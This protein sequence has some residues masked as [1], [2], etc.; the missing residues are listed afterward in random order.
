MIAHGSVV[1]SALIG[2][3][4]G[5]L[6]S[7]TLFAVS[8]KYTFANDWFLAVMVVF[9]NTTGFAVAA[10]FG[11]KLL[12]V[13]VAGLAG[14]MVGGWLGVRLIGS[15]EYTVP[16]PREDRVLRVITKEGEREIG[17]RGVP[18]E[19]VKRIPV[20]GAVGT[21]GGW[22]VGASAY[23]WLSRRRSKGPAIEREEEQFDAV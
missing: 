15:Y 19:T 18:E 2:A 6:E 22:A 4:Q 20:G 13:A 10:R 12:G 17:L 1:K 16:T 21:L 11:L 23:G 7:A 9:A 3:A 14:M 8:E 5:A